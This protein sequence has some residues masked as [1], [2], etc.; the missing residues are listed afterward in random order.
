MCLVT[1]GR[2]LEF[3]VSAVHKEQDEEEEEEGAAS[4]LGKENER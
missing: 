4:V 2:R 1:E 3:A